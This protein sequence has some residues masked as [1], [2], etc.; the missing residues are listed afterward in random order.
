M[1]V[2]RRRDVKCAKCGTISMSGY[3]I[4]ESLVKGVFTCVTSCP[5]PLSSEWDPDG[6]IPRPSYVAYWRF[7]DW[8][9][10]WSGFVKRTTRV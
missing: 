9:E 8:R 7:E 3:R 5:G 2:K 1:E 4:Q 6:L 10:Q